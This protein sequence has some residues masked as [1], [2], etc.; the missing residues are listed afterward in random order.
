M[1]SFVGS[2]VDYLKGVD[3]R[4]YL[5]LDRNRKHKLRGLPYS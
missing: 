2:F 1:L 5:G 3:T 4:T